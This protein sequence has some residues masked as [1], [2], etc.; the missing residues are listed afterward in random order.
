[1]SA[2]E[3]FDSPEGD[4]LPKRFRVSFG[5]ISFDI[6]P[7]SLGFI[8]MGRAFNAPPHHLYPH[9]LGDPNPQINPH[10]FLRLIAVGKPPHPGLWIACE[11]L[12]GLNQHCGAL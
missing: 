1:M 10:R 3:A 7:S 11:P 2:Y 6:K 5:I 4:R 9:A 12:S 8:A